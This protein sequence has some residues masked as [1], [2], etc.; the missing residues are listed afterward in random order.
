MSADAPAPPRWY[1][2]MLARRPDQ[3]HRAATPLELFYDLVFVVAIA[4]AAVG[5]HH[6]LAEDHWQSGLLG[7]AMVFFAIW[8]TWLNFA[9]F[10]SAYDTD[11]TPY[12]IAVMVQMAG[13]L[14]L[15]AGVEPAFEDQDFMTVIIG[16]SVIRAAMVAQW[17]RA[18]RSDP[19]RRTTCLRYAVGLIV[20]QLL[21]ITAGLTVEG[22]A[23]IFVWLVLVAVDMAVPV[24]AERAAPTT[25]HAHHITERYGLLT[26]I[27]LGETVLAA[28]MGV[29]SALEI[30]HDRTQVL[31]IAVA[32]LVTVFSMWWLYFDRPAHDLLTNLR[33]AFRWGYGHYV[34]FGSAAAVGA[35][36]EVILGNVEGESHLSD[37]AAAAPLTIAVAVYILSVWALQ[38]LPRDDVPLRWAYPACAVLAAL[39]AF[40]PQPVVVTAILLAALVAWTVTV[41]H[42]EA[43]RT[44]QH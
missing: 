42:R 39:A 24:H 15:A 6:A 33:M 7:Y 13:A 30:G 21:W 5:L 1:K 14:I 10:A 17:F 29:H 2:P 44:A 41:N 26:I 4:Q 34:V 28:T 38:I 32:G 3:E 22:T 36:L 12:R 43:L 18:A 11:D 20:V 31:V 37:T 19:E 27:V 35:G 23:F 9:W 40:A 16:Y 8:W 25:W